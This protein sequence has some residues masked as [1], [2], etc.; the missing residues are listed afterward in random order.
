MKLRICAFLMFTFFGQSTATASD[1]INFLYTEQPIVTPTMALPGEHQVGVTTLTIDGP[2][3]LKS[4]KGRSLTLEA[5][6]PTQDQKED[7]AVYQDLTRSH[8]PFR[9]QGKAI[10]DA[11][12]L[13]QIND[14]PAKFPLVVLS[15]GYTGYRTIMFYLG[16]HLAS[17]GYVVIS[18]DHTDS[19]NRDVDFSKSPGSGFLSTLLHRARDQQAVLDFVATSKESFLNA[20]SNSCLL[21]TSPSPRDA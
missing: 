6:Y 12:P 13:T 17:R 21:Y 7:Y 9:M 19:T 16:E 20:D 4:E 3:L 5:W 11:A 1:M 15:H 10:R 18:I 14:E 2:N 8:K